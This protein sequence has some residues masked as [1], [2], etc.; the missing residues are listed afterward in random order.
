MTYPLDEPEQGAMTGAAD[1]VLL[2]GP[3]HER[4]VLLIKRGWAPHR[5]C[6]ALPGGLVDTGETFLE[7]A[8]REAVEETGIDPVGLLNQVGVY[9]TPDRDPRGRVVSVAYYAALPDMPDPLAGDDAAAAQWVLA[10]TAL[11]ESLAFDHR[12]I[13]VDALRLDG[14]LPTAALAEM[15]DWA[16]RHVWDDDE[17]IE[18]VDVDAVEAVKDHYTGGITRFLRDLN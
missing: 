10:T 18:A 2:A 9:D 13:L 4:H 3:L 5:G 8:S 15:R 14:S 12:E 17:A 7:A 1:V 11:D 6:W 16:Q